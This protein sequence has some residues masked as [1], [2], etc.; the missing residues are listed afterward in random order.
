MHRLRF[1][2]LTAS[3]CGVLAG[4]AAAQ[5][6]ALLWARSFTGGGLQDANALALRTNKLWVGGSFITTINFGGAV[7]NSPL[8]AYI[9]LF[10]TDGAYQ[11]SAAFNLGGG[12]LLAAAVDSGDNVYVAG[13]FDGTTNFGGS[14][15]TTAGSYDIF[16]AKYNSAGVH[17]W[18]KKFGGTSQDMGLSL[19]VDNANNVIVGGRF[20]GSVDFGGGALVSAGSYDAFIAKFN[21]GGTHVWSQRFGDALSQEVD[22]LGTSNG[23]VYAAGTFFGTVNLGGSALTSAGNSDIFLA[24]FN[25]AGAHQWSQRYGD[26]A[27]QTVIDVDADNQSVALV[28]NVGGSIN[29][30]G[31][32]L[33]GAGSTDIA[34]ARFLVAGTHSWS[35]IY[36]DQDVQNAAAIDI[37]GG[38]I[39]VT[40]WF[41]GGINFGH[42]LSAGPS[43]SNIFVARLLATDGSETWS[44]SLGFTGNSDFGGDII[45]SGSQAWC[46]GRFDKDVNFG[47]NGTLFSQTRDSDAYVAQLGNFTVEPDIV[48]VE[49]VDN[50]QGGKVRL[51]WT[52]SEYDITT[53]VLP[54][55]NYE[56]YLRDDP[57]GLNAAAS[58]AAETWILAGEAPAH[59]L[60]NYYAL[61][62]TQQ[63]ATAA[64]GM[65]ASV[66]KVRATTDDP[67]LFFDSPS[68]SGLSLDNL[69]PAVPLNLVLTDG[70]LS[71]R[72]PDDDDVAY[73]TVYGSSGAFDESA[74]L[75]DYTTTTRINV[76]ERAFPRF[77][78]TATDRAG[79]ESEAASLD[80]TRTVS[81]APPRTLS[82]SAYPN[83]FNPATTIRY[84]LPVSGHVHVDVFN[85]NGARVR[86]VV[87]GQ[88]PAGAFTA[89][90]DGRNDA[91]G[92]VAS[93]VYFVRVEHSGA[94]RAYKL[95]MLK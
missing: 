46:A 74:Q 44:Q 80:G 58:A 60:V 63:D 79:N 81:P 87:D 19:V 77:F 25:S 53:S 68:L 20:M 89:G 28:A 42:P 16:L 62:F 36:G 38:S 88:S 22:G 29:F 85:A 18:S 65:H 95:V 49:D 21:S 43:N 94:T 86:T 1:A 82:V 91:G 9:A 45:S 23:D 37:A 33:T 35:K 59:G 83:P 92:R 50:D 11:W 27:T 15:L 47:F 54:I 8:N 73:Y 66:Y 12:S 64:N 13:F 10:T 76:T 40:G 17:Q 31:S 2:A 72:A 52:T 56:I 7:H 57:L 71:W 69:A 24:R 78:V 30:G 39:F 3:L 48:A 84:T 41:E 26:A 75:L 55:R 5:T 61:A 70:E 4:P 90:W 32:T 93:G 34:I 67:A 14:A 51:R 6:P